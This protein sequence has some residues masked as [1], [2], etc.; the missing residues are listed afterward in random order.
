MLDY[1]GT[2]IDPHPMPSY[3]SA[4]DNE[5]FVE[6]AVAGHWLTQVDGRGLEVG[7]VLAHYRIDAPRIVVDRYEQAPGVYNIDALAVDGTYPWVVSISTLEHVG[8]DP[9]EPRQP[10]RALDA[11]LHLRSLLADGGRMLVTVPLGWNPPLDEAIAAGVSAPTRDCVYV[12]D[13]AGVWR[14]HG[15]RT[16]A[17][18]GVTDAWAGAVWVAEWET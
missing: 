4:W 12:R 15:A 14:Q 7:N 10:G 2:P 6:L 1:Y 11:L 9:P 3:N 18:Y 17:P 8:W 5:R 16:W 13:L